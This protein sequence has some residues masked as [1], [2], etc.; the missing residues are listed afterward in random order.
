MN[1]TLLIGGG[2]ALGLGFFL[3][4]K[5]AKA[6]TA[7]G[8]KGYGPAP[9]VENRSKPGTTDEAK[10]LEAKADKLRKEILSSSGLEAAA[11]L[12][13]E[14]YSVRKQLGNEGL[15]DEVQAHLYDL[16]SA[17]V[18]RAGGWGPGGEETGT[19]DEDEV[20][21]L[22]AY[23]PQIEIVD[24]E[25]EAQL[26]VLATYIE[27]IKSEKVPPSRAQEFYDTGMGALASDPPDFVLA[28]NMIDALYDQGHD[29]KG[30]RL[31]EAMQRRYDEYAQGGN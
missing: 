8:G 18:N 30:A 29:G 2:L 7:P 3:W 4:P 1:K 22:H 15:D 19:Q 24:G 13:A 25:F 14:Y 20:Y 23:L 31:A 10:A 28:G 16:A 26:A 12:R 27:Q 5:D 9:H 11:Q 17:A 6:G 21:E